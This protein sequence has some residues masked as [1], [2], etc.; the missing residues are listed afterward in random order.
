MY[1]KNISPGDV[2]WGLCG[3]IWYPAKVCSLLDLPED[4]QNSFRN[5]QQKLILKWYGEN[6]FSLVRASKVEQLAENKVDAQRASRSA[7]MQILY[8]TALE[9]LLD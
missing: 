2:V 1:P 4:M 8:N 7:K 9:D 5:S 6:N 3:R